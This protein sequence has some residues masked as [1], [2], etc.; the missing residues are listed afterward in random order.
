MTGARRILRVILTLVALLG[1]SPAE[2]QSRWGRL[3]P[4]LF[5]TSDY[6]YD[7]LSLSGHE[8]TPQASLYWWRPDKFY[9]GVWVSCVDFSDLGDATTSYEVDVY[10]GRNFDI[11]RTQFTLEGMYTFFPDEDI[12]GPTYD[13]VTAKARL[14]HSVDA[15]T[16]GSAVAWVPEASYGAGVA[17]RLTGEASYMWAKWLKT[18]G[19][20]GRRWNARNADRTFWDVSA[21]T[22]WKKISVELRYSDTDLGFAECGF[23]NWCEA[24]LVATLQVDLWR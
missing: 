12:P 23:V 1:V 22:A 16:F 7:G 9:S 3:Y 8:P 21:T 18:S 24:G 17:W 10:A 2:A 15:L 19:Q 20:V 4:S 6:R 13:F 11:G 5:L 14:R